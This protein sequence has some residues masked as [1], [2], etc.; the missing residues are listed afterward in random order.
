[1]PEMKDMKME[2]RSEPMGA[3]IPEYPEYPYGLKID[4]CEQE[5]EKLG[6]DKMPAPGTKITG[7]FVAVIETASIRKTEETTDR[8]L[9]M[10]IVKLGL[11][12]AEAGESE[13]RQSKPKEIQNKPSK[14]GPSV[15]KVLYSD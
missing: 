6:M 1:M 2:K 13:S 12:K 4:L 14:D 3:A 8:N 5:I 10:Q 9:C 15:E 7:S 11:G